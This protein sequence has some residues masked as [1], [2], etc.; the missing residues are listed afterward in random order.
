M[1]KS[2][3]RSSIDTVNLEV[4]MNAD[5]SFQNRVL[6]PIIKSQHN[7]IL[8]HF[9]DYLDVRKLD[10]T[11]LNESDQKEFIKS[12]IQKELSLKSELVGMIV[13]QLDI[14]EYDQYSRIRR[15]MNKR[16]STIIIERLC[17]H[18]DDLEI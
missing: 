16:I 12:R 18:L 15:E 5:E 13:G 14:E 7:L 2:K 10:L 11:V 3:L 4:P 17:T 9:R 8:A 6:R 1:V